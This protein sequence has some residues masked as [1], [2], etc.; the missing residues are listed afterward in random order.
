[1]KLWLTGVDICDY[2]KDL[3]GAPTIGADDATIAAPSGRKLK[4]PQAFP[5]SMAVEVDEDLYRL[6]AEE[7][8]LMPHIHVSLQAG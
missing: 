3:P 6:I 7:P 4:T 5:R 2:G 1:V 8:R